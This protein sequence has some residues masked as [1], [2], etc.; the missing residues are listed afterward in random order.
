MACPCR[1]SQSRDGEQVMPSRIS[2]GQIRERG[3][4]RVS[5]DLWRWVGLFGA[6]VLIAAFVVRTWVVP[7]LIVDQLTSRYAGHI[8][9]MDWWLGWSS[10][11]LVGLHLC[12]GPTAD[13][14]VWMS[15]E[16]VTA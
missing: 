10:S 8:I 9:V 15:A 6:V 11:G 13:S 1:S 5:R 7:A 14:P 3:R 4:M 16:R 2:V 12:E